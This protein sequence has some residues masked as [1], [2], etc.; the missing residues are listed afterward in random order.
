MKV[1][2][3]CICVAVALG[4]QLSSPEFAS[5]YQ[6]NEEMDEF[7][8][9]ML[10]ATDDPY[11]E[12]AEENVDDA[13]LSDDEDIVDGGE[14]EDEVLYANVTGDGM[15]EVEDMVISPD[16]FDVMFPHLP[17]HPENSASASIHR[18]AALSSSSK[19]WPSG[20]IYFAYHSLLS[21][22][23]SKIRAAMSEWEKYTCLKFYYRKSGAT[24]YTQIRNSDGRCSSTLGYTGRLQYINLGKNCYSHRTLLHEIGHTLGLIHEHQHPSRDN[25]VTII[26]NN[27]N[28]EKVS[29]F[30]SKSGVSSYGF[31]YDPL[32]VMHY[33][34]K[35]FKKSGCKYPCYT[36]QSKKGSSQ[37]RLIGTGKNLSKKSDIPI[38]KKMYRCSK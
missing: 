7:T 21:G 15:I 4:A 27:V 23:K 30:K 36:I 37:T 29:N 31:A 12:A 9:A 1:I 5:P 18:R 26:W 6:Q 14:I 16:M 8:A 25:Y 19:L 38:I 28:P 20:R 3:V 33:T 22:S 2:I 34:A 24:K 13:D 35:S 11:D 32:S 10:E 17:D